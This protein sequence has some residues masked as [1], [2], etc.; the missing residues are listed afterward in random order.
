MSEI[1]Q[2]KFAVPQPGSIRRVENIG[3]DMPVL[4][5]GEALGLVCGQIERLEQQVG[6][7]HQRMGP[8]LSPPTPEAAAI[9]ATPPTDSEIP[10]VIVNHAGR[11][12]L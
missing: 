12:R 10:A 2:S 6:D 1:G 4:G 8:I 3:P 9:Y 7:L 11:L 5:I